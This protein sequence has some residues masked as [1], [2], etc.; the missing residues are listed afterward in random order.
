MTGSSSETISVFYIVVGNATWTV[1]NIVNSTLAADSQDIAVV[2][3]RT[4]R[5]DAY[6]MQLQA[7][8]SECMYYIQLA[9]F[10]LAEVQGLLGSHFFCLLPQISAQHLATFPGGAS[11]PPSITHNAGRAIARRDALHSIHENTYYRHVAWHVSSRAA[12]PAERL[13]SGGHAATY[14]APY[15][16]FLSAASRVATAA[17]TSRMT[18]YLRSATPSRALTKNAGCPAPLNDANVRSRAARLRRQQLCR[19]EPHHAPDSDRRTLLLSIAGLATASLDV[20]V[21]GALHQ[22]LALWQQELQFYQRQLQSVVQQFL[23]LESSPAVAFVDD[24]ELDTDL[25]SQLLSAPLR[26]LQAG[27]ARP[28]CG[29]IFVDG[30]CRP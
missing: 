19:C 3:I 2:G 26:A 15:H 6:I 10:V 18:A 16:E 4:R 30:C 13:Y 7:K 11:D 24:V 27:G 20:D 12:V 17:Y 25:A 5:Y 14:L 1:S 23:P 29:S 28:C 9:R 8:L 22:E 21:G